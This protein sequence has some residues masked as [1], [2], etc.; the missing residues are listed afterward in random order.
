MLD[1]ARADDADMLERLLDARYSCRG[2][3][4]DPVPRE[5]IERVLTLAQRTASW[6]NSQPWRMAI[7]SGAALARLR[8]ALLAEA[9]SG[10]GEPDFPWPAEYRGVYQERRRECGLQLYEA[11]GVAR[12]DRAG[13]TRQMLENFRFFG[14]PHVALVTSDAALGVYGAVDCGAYVA[15][16]TLAARACGVD[17][18]AQA[19]LARHSGLIRG[20][21][22]LGDDR[23]VVCG[24]SFGYADP[25]HPANTFRTTRAR[26]DDAATF[27]DE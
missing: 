6:C 15:M 1:H 2:F 27:F 8:D 25:A 4:P 21:F 10:G 17:T 5:T 26:L 3:K 20:Q 13:A 18:I 9:A 16:F 11:V 12:G 22:A 23:R 14:A 7:A 19:A 24:I